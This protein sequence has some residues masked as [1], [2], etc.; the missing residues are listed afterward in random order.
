MRAS[1]KVWQNPVENTKASSILCPKTHLASNDK[2][3]KPKKL[4][5]NVKQIIKQVSN[6][7]NVKSKL[8]RNIKRDT[9][10]YVKNNLLR[11]ILHRLNIVI[12]GFIEHI[13]RGMS[14]TGI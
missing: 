11:G 9:T 6:K 3:K 4:S 5:K 12:P 8:T 14:N 1:L 10:Y 13:I 2:K 7:V